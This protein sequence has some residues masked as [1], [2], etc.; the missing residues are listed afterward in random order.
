MSDL[1][2][3]I[4]CKKIFD[5]YEYNNHICVEVINNGQDWVI[6]DN[7]VIYVKPPDPEINEILIL[8]REIHA[9]LKTWKG[10]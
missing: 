1:Y 9:M 2:Q 6:P 8:V 10:E 7:N 5:E 3:C 4:T